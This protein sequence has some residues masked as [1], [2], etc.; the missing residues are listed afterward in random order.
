MYQSSL[1]QGFTEGYQKVSSELKDLPLTSCEESCHCNAC[2]TDVF[3]NK[4]A[5]M[6]HGPT[7]QLVNGYVI[8]KFYDEKHNR[9]CLES[10]K[11]VYAL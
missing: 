4:N 8:L 3:Y 11:M 2:Q 5:P 7:L 10:H 1:L 9:E 6:T